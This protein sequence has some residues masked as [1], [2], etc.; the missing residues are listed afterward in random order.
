VVLQPPSKF[1]VGLAELYVRKCYLEIFALIQ[2]RYD[3]GREYDGVVVTGNPG[4]GKSS[5]LS[6]ILCCVASLEICVVYESTVD[7]TAWLF[8]F[9]K[10]DA[11]VQKVNTKS[12]VVEV[13][14]E[15][16]LAD[17]N[18]VFL[19]DTDASCQLEPVR[20]TAFTIIAASPKKIHF[21]VFLDRSAPSRTLKLYMPVWSLKE[22]LDCHKC[23]SLYENITTDDITSAFSLF[24]GI[25]RYVMSSGE[26]RGALVVRLKN[27]LQQC[28]AKSLIDC[29]G[30]LDT[31][32]DSHMLLHYELTDAYR[33]V[34]TTFASPWVFEQLADKWEREDKLVAEH[35]VSQTS[36]VAQLGG[37]RGYALERVA[38]RKLASGGIFKVRRLHEDGVE[39][40]EQTVN[41]RPLDTIEFDK[42]EDIQ[43]DV[44]AYLKPKS[45]TLTVVDAVSIRK[46]DEETGFQM[47]VSLS[48]RAKHQRV[49][50]ILEKLSIKKPRIFRL[51]FVVPEDKFVE[52]QFQKYL[53]ARGQG[54]MKAIGVVKQVEQWVLLL[55]IVGPRTGE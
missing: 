38:H 34:T 4:I 39:T 45:K 52:F 2:K 37:A 25:P 33:T 19:F 17:R 36:G 44:K 6:Y 27:E 21:K 43:A 30:N 11:R 29:V 48:H 18:T 1:L 9:S 3:E 41:F 15:E 12:V 28:Q 49:K 51:Y 35:F 22:L 40:A 32:K 42:L 53:K 46:T 14:F 54:T 47:T 50:E 31:T 16:V 23:T 24:G 26:D 8:D 20:C 7:H 10:P 13:A 5:F 55:P